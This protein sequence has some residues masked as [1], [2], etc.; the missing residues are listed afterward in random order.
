MKPRYLLLLGA[1]ILS[2]AAYSVFWYMAAS[3]ARKDFTAWADA[4]NAQGFA[5]AYDD[6]SVDGYPFR[7]ITHVGKLDW[8]FPTAGGMAHWRSENL[9][10]VGE[11]WEPGHVVMLLN[12][13][14]DVEVPAGETTHRY[15]IEAARAR[16]SF[17]TP[18]DGGPTRFSFASEHLDIANVETAEHV[19]AGVAQLY[20]LQM[21]PSPAQ[22]STSGQD[23]ALPVTAQ[24]DVRIE[25][26]SLPRGK[27]GTLA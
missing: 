19:T 3:G 7:L 1:V 27:G 23:P 12:G 11:P 10:I 9:L 6:V 21:P 8:G 25:D 20:L 14:Q 13:K 5:I 22:K 16:A 24:V 26:G 17:V 4:A 18:Q 15:S 2:V